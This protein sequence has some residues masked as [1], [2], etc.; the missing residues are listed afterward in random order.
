MAKRE[1]T[2]NKFLTMKL[3]GS[4][5]YIY[6]AGEKFKQCR[7]LMI[8]LPLEEIESFDE[9][10]SIDEAAE[11]I[12][13]SM[14]E[15]PEPEKIR[16][17]EIPT[18][19]IL[20]EEEFWGLCSNLQ[21]WYEHGYNTRLLHSN[22]SFPLLKRLVD[23]G[24]IQAKRIFKEEIIDR[25]NNGVESVRIYL[26]R[27]NYLSYL[28]LKE[29]LSI[30]EDEDEREAMILLTNKLLRTDNLDIDI[31]EGRV[32]KIRLQAQE[33]RKV[34]ESV[35]K[36]TSLEHL[37]LSYNLLEELPEWIG[38]LKTLK[39][40]EVSD[41]C[42]KTL[43][44]SI[45]DL[46][47]LEKLIACSNKIEL[48]PESFGGLESLKVIELYENRLNSLPDSLGNL[49]N[50][51]KLDLHKNLI[52]LLPQSIG[53][54]KNL[55]VLD[56]SENSI[57]DLP[58]S[59]EKLGNL[60]KFSIANNKLKTLPPSIYSIKSLEILSISA[61]P[62]QYF[63]DFIY[64][65]PKLKEIFVRELGVIGR[66]INKYYFWN[67]YIVIFSDYKNKKKDVKSNS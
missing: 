8:N 67:K 50:L 22:L 57:Q 66:Q 52:N 11:I 65:L 17:H 45:G 5:T 28:S 10:K 6:V 60:T 40:I 55:K 33:L 3:E 34:P 51:E 46:K 27:M 62:L 35:R 12:N 42:L 41:N 25:Y 24:D 64:Q 61:N 32:I 2:I 44:D 43:P 47:S 49:F 30:V 56:L 37:I 13:P 54:L 38:E 14:R 31:K 19:K 53:N 59:I 18:Y 23:V 26:R 21:A 7:F 48:L 36:L 9:I 58:D 16:R 29:L 63:P 15:P 20:P 4:K 39:I 1:F